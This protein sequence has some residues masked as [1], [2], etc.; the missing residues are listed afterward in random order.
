MRRLETSSLGVVAGH[1]TTLDGVVDDVL[2]AVA[3]EGDAVLECVAEGLDALVRPP[4]A[5]GALGLLVLLVLLVLRLVVE[6]LA[7]EPETRLERL[8]F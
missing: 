4:G 3:R 7:L 5:G 2:K 1:A 6:R 8:D